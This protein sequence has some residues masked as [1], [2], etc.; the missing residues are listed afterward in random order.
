MEPNS[1]DLLEQKVTKLLQQCVQLKIENQQLKERNQTLQGM[2][3]DKDAII[4]Q[5]NQDSEGVVGLK[6]EIETYKEKQDRIRNK[7]ES[8][9]EKL[10][11][12]EEIR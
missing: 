8:L 12:F 10:K 6:N 2:L 7:V 4:Q 1:F 11:E 5:L 3:N 9:L